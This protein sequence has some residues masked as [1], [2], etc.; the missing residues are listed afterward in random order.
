MTKIETKR[1]KELIEEAIY[2]AGQF[3]FIES[4]LFDLLEEIKK[5][6][7]TKKELKMGA[8]ELIDFYGK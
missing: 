8:Q 2:L 7:P 6:K 5:L 3:D 1:R 4:Q